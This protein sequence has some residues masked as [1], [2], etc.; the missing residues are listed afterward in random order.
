MLAN[1]SS[2][3]SAF[4]IVVRS[5]APSRSTPLQAF[6]REVSTPLLVEAVVASSVLVPFG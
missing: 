1:V 5:L 2:E 3:R 6:R 4:I